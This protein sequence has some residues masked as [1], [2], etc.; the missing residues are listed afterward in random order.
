MVGHSAGGRAIADQGAAGARVLIP[1]AA[2]G[3]TPA[4]ALESTL[5][6]GG[7][8]DAVVEYAEQVSGYEA[9]PSAKRLVGIEGAGHL[10]PTDLC[11]LANAAGENLVA[12][13]Q[14][15]QIENAEFAPALFD[16]P[17]G[18]PPAETNRAIVS[19][20]TASALE[21]T[22]SCDERASFEGLQARFPEVT[23]LR[24]EL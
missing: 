15:H 14:K 23:E 22:L 24:E 7:T 13:A 20:A 5:V 6:M 1:L 21:S 10:F 19:Y 2:G 11:H 9:S 3:T 8:A 17:A 12:I 16:C 4:S 18:E